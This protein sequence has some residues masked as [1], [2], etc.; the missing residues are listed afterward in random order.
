[1]NVIDRDIEIVKIMMIKEE[2]KLFPRDIKQFHRTKMTKQIYKKLKDNN[3]NNKK[4]I[5][6]DLIEFYYAKHI[7]NSFEGFE[8]GPLYLPYI[9]KLN[10]S[11]YPN[12]HFELDKTTGQMILYALRDIEKGEEINDSYLLNKKITNHKEYLRE[13]YNFVCNC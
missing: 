12:T 7:Y 8:Y 10:H 11:C 1:M 5:Q 3:I 6:D 13:H 9:A 2:D 4:K